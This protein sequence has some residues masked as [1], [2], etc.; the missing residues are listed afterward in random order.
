ME[1][2]W[3]N[4]SHPMVAVPRKHCTFH[5]KKQYNR[6]E[7]RITRAA[8]DGVISK[9]ALTEG[10]RRDQRTIAKATLFGGVGVS[11]SSIHFPLMSRW[12][13]GD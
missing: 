4:E 7:A 12:H 6:L 5:G 13:Y 1:P 11:C 9:G 2:R 10:V 8:C 3:K